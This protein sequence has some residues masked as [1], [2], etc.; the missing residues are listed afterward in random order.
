MSNVD[1]I[2]E[3]LSIVDVVGSHLKLQKAGS[4]FKANCPFHNE[5]TPSFFVSPDRDSYYC[6]GC[7]AKGDIFTFVQE[8]EGLDFLGALKILAHRSGVD[9]DFE[10]KQDRGEKERMLELIDHAASFFEENLRNDKLAREYLKRRSVEENTLSSWRI[11]YAKDR[12]QDLI[13]FL[14]NKG[15]KES[16]LQKTGLAK[17][18]E[19]GKLYDVFRNRIIFPIFD[20]AGRIIA[21][22]G[23]LFPEKENAPKY[24]NS[25]ETEFFN[26]SEIL[27]GFDR[28]K[29]EI[30]TKNY[31]ILVEGQ[32]DLILSHQAGFCNTVA[33]SGTALTEK[34]LQRLKRL[35][36]R[37]IFAYDGDAAGFKAI[38]RAAKLAIP[39]HMNVRVAALPNG[40]DPALFIAKDKNEYLK[41][42][43]DSRH[44][45]DFYLDKIL[46]AKMDR[47]R[48]D[49]EIMK[50][51]LP[52]LK[53]LPSSIEQARF[54]A[55]VSERVNIPEAAVWSD[56]QKV[57]LEL[58]SVES[59]ISVTDKSLTDRKSSIMLRLAGI[60]F[61]LDGKGQKP[62]ISDIKGKIEEFSDLDFEYFLKQN[63]SKKDELTFEA[64]AY[65]SDRDDIGDIVEDL[66]FNLHEEVLKNALAEVF[67]E[68]QQAENSRD[69]DK[70]E[71]LL[72]KSQDLSKKIN[73]LKLERQK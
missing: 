8:M 28:A 29:N 68:I 57:D 41:I 22:S 43:K 21:F 56:L 50:K 47:R 35:S 37:I 7:G 3:R 65:F 55:S 45:I 2:K 16:E 48:Q 26:K 66:I 58:D 71:T 63:D 6:F 39:F 67:K 27:Y 19:D 69:R 61:W 9:L 14:K 40:E 25:P 31:S 52:F 51:V 70:V 1:K 38:E 72:L 30:R 11:G 53:L 54:V 23:R 24:L 44:I 59:E 32:M 62:T 42:L 34:Q 18:T 15:F 73:Q 20:S 13:D 33:T 60:A 17:K 4:N 49:Q 64:E 5:K 46:E 12:W 36:E 10:K